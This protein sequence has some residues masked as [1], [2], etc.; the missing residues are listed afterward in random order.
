VNSCNIGTLVKL[1]AIIPHYIVCAGCMH[2][3]D[4][5][6]TRSVTLDVKVGK[7]EHGTSK[8]ETRLLSLATFGSSSDL[9]SANSNHNPKVF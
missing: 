1:F 3:K 9:D 6:T 2:S 4:Q 8:D 5:L 7:Y